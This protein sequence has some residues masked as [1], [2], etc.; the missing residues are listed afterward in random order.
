MARNWTTADMPS[1]AGKTFIVT[2]ASSGI[3]EVAARELAR[4][5]AY[6]VLA[7]R[8]TGKGER[9]AATMPPN[10]EVRRLDVADLSSVRTFAAGWTRPFHG[11]VNNAGIMGAP[12][13][14]T[15]D[16]FE[17]HIGTNHLGPFLLTSLMLPHVTDRVVTL[18][19]QLGRLGR[20]RLDDLNRERRAYSDVQAYCD[21]RL[22]NLQ[23]ALE[24]Q[25]RLDAAGSAVRSVA[26]HPGTAATSLAANVDGLAGLIAARTAWLFN[27]AD[28]GALPILYA[29][30]MDIPGGSLIGPNGFQHLRGYPAPRKPPRRALDAGQAWELWEAS[31]QL[32][33]AKNTLAPAPA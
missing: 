13:G 27:D 11:L 12:E 7:V 20:V 24:L 9:A 2:G 19:S 23:F 25:R 1:Q 16:G 14:R 26:A 17:L 3:G 21:S 4:A 29:A 32:T 10:T 22:A 33:G 30:T 28:K 8:D 5:G 6:V 15:V 18:T 31:A